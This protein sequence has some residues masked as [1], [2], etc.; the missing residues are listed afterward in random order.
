VQVLAICRPAGG[1]DAQSAFGP[2]LE[3]EM[4]ALRRMRDAGSLERA[5][6]VGHPGAVLVLVADNVD[7]ARAQAAGL[8]LARA[9]LVDV[10]LIPLHPLPL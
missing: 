4:A 9:G 2:H 5:Y 1:V 7:A 8:P 3:A 10:E 6:S